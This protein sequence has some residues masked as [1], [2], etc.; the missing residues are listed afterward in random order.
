MLT[1]ALVAV[2]VVGFLLWKLS[3][4]PKF[5]LPLPPGPPAEAVFG[6]VRLIPADRPEVQYANWSKEYSQF[7][8]N[9]NA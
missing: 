5:P 4:Q 7:M 1:I 8:W 6:H 2:T 3:A 9:I